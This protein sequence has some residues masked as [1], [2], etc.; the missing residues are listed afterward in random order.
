MPPARLRPG[1]TVRH[2]RQYGAALLLLEP[3][4]DLLAARL[5]P[6]EDVRGR[7]ERILARIGRTEEVSG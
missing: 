2:L 7:L 1:W 3:F 5:C 4:I 6:S